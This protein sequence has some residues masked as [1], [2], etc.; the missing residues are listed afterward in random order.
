MR[1]LRDDGIEHIAFEARFGPNELYEL[2]VELVEDIAA[3]QG[4]PNE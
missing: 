4:E 1:C 3:E 2:V